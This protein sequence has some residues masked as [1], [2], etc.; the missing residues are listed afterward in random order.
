MSISQSQDAWYIYV[1]I[2][3]VFLLRHFPKEGGHWEE[4]QDGRVRAAVT[5]CS[6]PAI[7]RGILLSPGIGPDTWHMSTTQA[8]IPTW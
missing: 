5:R 1:G 4:T 6:D 8:F 7:L 3:T 2:L